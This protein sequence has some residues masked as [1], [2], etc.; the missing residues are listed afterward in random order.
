M[1]SPTDELE[2]VSNWV[3]PEEWYGVTDPWTGALWSKLTGD[4]R[5]AQQIAADLGGGQIVV[6]TTRIGADADG[7]Y[8]APF[9][10]ER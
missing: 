4:W 5:E 6:V 7:E 8:V 3:D 1:P 2:R 9:I 10:P